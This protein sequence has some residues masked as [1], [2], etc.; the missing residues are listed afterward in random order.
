M[1]FAQIAGLF[2]SYNQQPDL[3]ETSLLVLNQRVA[4]RAETKMTI[5][6]VAQIVLVIYKNVQEKGSLTAF[7]IK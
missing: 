2:E 5:V 7:L 6:L 3:A 4:E 1:L